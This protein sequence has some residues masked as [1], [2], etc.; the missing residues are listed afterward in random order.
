MSTK[1]NGDIAEQLVILEAM[2]RGFGVSRPIGD[3]LSY[4][5]II[6]SN[7]KLFKI[8]VKKAYP[9][10]KS[11]NNPNTKTYTVNTTRSCTNRKV[12][13]YKKYN[14]NDFDFAACVIFETSDIYIVPS[15]FF[16]SKKR[17]IIFVPDGYCDR[18]ENKNQIFRNNWNQLIAES[19]SQVNDTSLINSMATANV[20]SNPTSAIVSRK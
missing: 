3:R 7:G 15:S 5:L 6:D 17:A 13:L 1:L 9:T 11:D 8:Q 14:E 20:G 10:S 18:R 16:I 12:Y 2:S 4:D 19:S